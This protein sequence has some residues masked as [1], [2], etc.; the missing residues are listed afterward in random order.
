MSK[1]S[2][3]KTC[4]VAQ[5]MKRLL[6]LVLA[7]V[8]TACNAPGPAPSIAPVVSPSLIPSITLSPVPSA[9]PTS[10]PSPIPSADAPT[11]EP[12]RA[13][14]RSTFDRSLLPSVEKTLDLGQ[15][16]FADFDMPVPLAL[17][18]QADRLYVSLSPSR[19]IVL[20]AN[21][22]TPVGEI[23][24][25]G[26]LS[27]NPAANRLYIGVPGAYQTNPDGTGTLTPADLKL[28]DTANLT[29]LRG[30]ILSGTSTVPPVVAVDALHNKAYITQNG[31]TLADATTLAVQGTL[32]G[33]FPVPDAPVPNYTAVEAAIVP[34]QHRL[35]VSLNNGIPGSNNGNVLAIYDLASGHVIA[36]DMERSVSGFAV[37][38]ANGTVV[39]P[40]N[41]IDT[42]A[43]VK[44][45]AQGNVLKRLD[46]LS[47]LVQVD[48]TR[49]RVYSFGG[50]AGAQ[51][52]TFD[53]DLNFLGVSTY[54]SDG[55]GA[56]FA[57]VNSE[58]DRLYV[59]QRDGKLIVLTGHGEPIGLPPGPVPDRK[60]VLS[61]I[62]SSDDQR[63]FYALFAPDE[64][65]TDGSLFRTRDDGATWIVMNS[66][67][68][69]TALNVSHTLFVAVD[70]NGPAGLGVWRSS[71]EGQTWQPASHGLTDLAITRLAASPDFAR[72]GTL[73]A[74]SKRAVFRSTDRGT[75]WTPL[76][77]RYAPLLKDLTVSFNAIALSPDFA[78]DNTLLLGH[79]SGL[80]RSTD[81]GETWAT[82]NG[83][84]AATRLAYAPDGSIVLAAAYDGVHRSTD[85]GLTWQAFNVGLDLSNSTVGEVQINDR[86]AV[87]LVTSFDQPGAVYRLPLNETTWQRLSIDLDVTA[88]AVLPDG[89]LLIG[90]KDG[91]V[92]D[93]R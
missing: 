12:T 13:P 47:G 8:F 80:W 64:F 57:I 41:Y 84:P 67:P 49:D 30:L 17:D 7:L 52:A 50:G 61:L 66:W 22:L 54:P 77:D 33:T 74:L 23:P 39:A 63:S 16:R 76:A 11:N 29:V 72:D 92:R 3:L 85:G 78:H 38:E 86:E 89:S 1:Y 68:L 79:S 5:I 18:A 20:D 65:T 14:D 4:Q 48:P 10:K 83:G 21:T 25:G 6:L 73:F 59:L 58:R 87:V 81:R 70:R 93:Y 9:S 55:T 75:T 42:A 90:A 43:I 36:R 62:P 15:A 45:D 35:F 53:H 26:A 69:N 44:Y 28:I 37:D 88:L 82:I 27:V 31:I 71:D 19:T 2:E 51:I 32:S 91:S 56:Q 34:A 40:H 60:A 46:G 24:F